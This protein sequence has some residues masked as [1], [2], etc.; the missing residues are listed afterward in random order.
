MTTHTADGKEAVSRKS[1]KDF[2]QALENRYVFHKENAEKHVKVFKPMG[3][4]F[5]FA[6]PILAAV[7]AFSMSPDSGVSKQAAAGMGLVLT[8]LTIVNSILKPDKKFA[9]ATQNC[10]ALNDWKLEFDIRVAETATTDEKAFHAV[11]QD[12]DKK[13]S[14]IGK[15]MAEGYIPKAPA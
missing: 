8:L 15:A 10:I 4:I 6:V 1:L 14:D 3:F 9:E 5:A 12:M 13:L 7:V 2:Q 11:I